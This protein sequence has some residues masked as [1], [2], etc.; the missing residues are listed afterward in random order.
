M[1]EIIATVAVWAGILLLTEFL[2]YRKVLRGEYA[3]KAIH[4]VI[5]ISIA[6][7]PYYLSWSQIQVLGLVGLAGAIGVRYSGWFKGAYD[8]KRRSWGDII[9]PAAI[10]SV[11]F[12]EPPAIVFL[13]LM[14]HTGVADGVAAIVGTRYGKGSRYQV[15]GYTKSVAGTAAFFTTSFIATLGMILF[16]DIGSLARAWPLLLW[17]PVATTA[18]ENIG[19]YGIDNALITYMTVFIFSQY[20]IMADILP[21]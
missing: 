4:I 11:T 7:T 21:L 16:G 9:G 12:L 3:R 10:L 13:A 17:L 20:L 1:L 15:F 2:W 19:I 6:A 8:I 14:L 18:V 5:S